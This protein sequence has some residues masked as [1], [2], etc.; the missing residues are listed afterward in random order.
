MPQELTN[1]A[2]D[3]L[4][5]LELKGALNNEKKVLSFCCACCNLIFDKLPDNARNA[6]AVAERYIK[7][8]AN[9]QDLINARN[10]LWKF[11]GEDFMN[12][13][14]P[15]VAAIRAVICC[16][17]EIK[18]QDESFNSIAYVMGFCNYVEVK[19]SEQYNLL[20]EIFTEQS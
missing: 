7:G 2:R 19:S 9:L 8:S 20:V 14:N 15:N 12:F 18:N 3:Y 5:D 13:D 17:Y 10:A 1:D 6:L 16:L 11:L 4:E